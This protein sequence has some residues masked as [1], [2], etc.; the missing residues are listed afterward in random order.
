MHIYVIR[1]YT[2]LAKNRQ[3]ARYAQNGGMSIKIQKMH[4]LDHAKVSF[5]A[6]NILTRK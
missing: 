1:G 4:M 5:C 3:K 6:A 2:Q